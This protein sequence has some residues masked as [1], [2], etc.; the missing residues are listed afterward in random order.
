MKYKL[1]W[2]NEEEGILTCFDGEDFCLVVNCYVTGPEDAELQIQDIVSGQKNEK[3]DNL[4]EEII[5]KMTEC[6]SECFRLLWE[7]GY[8]ETVLVEKNGTKFAE[9]LNSTDVVQK[10]YSEYMMKRYIKT[11]KSTDCGLRSLSLTKTGEGYDCKNKEQSFFCRLLDYQGRQL[12]E[13][14]FY[15]YEVEVSKKERNK[16]IATACLTE[17]FRRLSA[18]TAVT[19]YL[20]VGS[21]NELAVHLY[22][23][24]GFEICEELRY[25]AMTE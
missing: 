21:Y 18:E 2:Q 25:Y 12:G 16:G 3:N 4:R 9:T 10:C 13:T 24:L 17:L 15:L 20:Q 22:E 5:L 19:I 7:E 11:E 1:E 14:A 23:K 8:E 6:L